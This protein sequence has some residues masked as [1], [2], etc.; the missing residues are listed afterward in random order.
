MFHG[1]HIVRV[2]GLRIQL[3]SIDFGHA[4]CGDHRI[5]MHLKKGTLNVGPDEQGLRV[6]VQGSDE[7]LTEQYVEAGDEYPLRS[8]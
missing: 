5:R 1:D 6:V 4:G 2:A 3:A 7:F 8:E